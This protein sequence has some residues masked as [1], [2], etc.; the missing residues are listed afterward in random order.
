MRHSGIQLTNLV[1]VIVV[2]VRCVEC[3]E[4]NGLLLM[5]QLQA[6]LINAAGVP[7]R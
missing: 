6:A 1:A 5:K 3:M 7:L 2:V 4:A